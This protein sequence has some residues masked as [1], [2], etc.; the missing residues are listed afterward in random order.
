M[1][2]V[3]YTAVF[4]NYDNV[5]IV[6][7]N[8]GWRKVLFTNTGPDKVPG[9]EVV[10]VKKPF[11]S[12]ALSNRYYK[13]FPHKHLKADVSVYIDGNFNVVGQLDEFISHM[14]DN[15]MLAFD[16]KCKPLPNNRICIYDEAQANIDQYKADK[17]KILQQMAQYRAEGYPEKNGLVN[18][19]VIARKHTNATT[20]AMQAWWKELLRWT[21][22]DMLSFNYI[23]WKL[24]YQ[25]K[26]LEMY[27]RDNKWFKMHHHT[28]DVKLESWTSN[29][30]YKLTTFIPYST[31]K[32]L[33]AEYNRCMEMIGE[34]DWAVLLDHDMMFLTLDW[35]NHIRYAIESLPNAGLI[36]VTTNRLGNRDQ[37]YNRVIS[38]NHDIRFHRQIAKKLKAHSHNRYIDATNRHLIGGVVMITSKRAWLKAGKFPDGL[39]SIDNLY[40]QRIRE[41]GFKV[42][43]MQ[44]LYVYHWRRGEGPDTKAHLL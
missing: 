32:N 9:W 29:S 39:I 23:A 30:M 31:D 13:L 6:D 40:H 20:I 3:I 11:L 27:V 26:S 5:N 16:S 7:N 34:D 37:V 36:T 38:D 35:Y 44:G 19:G 8:K 1:D 10:K 21:H 18:C 41:A 43:I 2:K 15:D 4:D 42:Y 14:G 17:T 12:G 22:R 33:G 24:N 28:K 25:F